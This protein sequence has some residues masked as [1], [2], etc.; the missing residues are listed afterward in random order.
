M[1][2]SDLA[3]RLDCRFDGRPDV[4]ISGVAHLDAATSTDLALCAG[5]RYFESLP[6]TRAGVVIL[7]LDSPAPP[8]AAIRSPQP[9]LT[10][11]RALALLRP[12]AAAA[13]GV[14]PAAVVA[15]TAVLGPGVSVGPCA[16]LGERVQVGEGTRIYPNVTIGDDVVLGRGC[17]VHAGASIRERVHIGDRVL[18]HDGAVLGADGFGF[19][20][21]PDGVYE[22]IPQ[23]ADV[24]IED[25]VEIGANTTIDRPPL[26]ETRIG[27]GSKIDNLVQVAHGS[28]I[29]RNVVLA[30]QV[31]LAGSVRLEDGVVA[32]GRVGVSDHVTVGRGARLSGGTVVSKDVDPGDQLAGYPAMPVAQWRR[33]SVIFRTLPALKRRLDALEARLAA[34]ISKEPQ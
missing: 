28:H 31:G 10:F 3:A 19:V 25:D 2:L 12:T 24:V 34:L 11:A 1:Q 5:G 32:G 30:A 22:K 8:C 21:R 7:P 26:G 16:V 33:A 23:T 27:A 29:G 14:H 4:E 9:Y 13:P 20:R 15:A 6:R 17:I 18:I